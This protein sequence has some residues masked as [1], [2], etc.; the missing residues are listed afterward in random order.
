M[1]FAMVDHSLY[2]V[3]AHYGLTNKIHCNRASEQYREQDEDP[4]EVGGLE[5]KEAEKVVDNKGVSPAA[6]VDYHGGEGLPEKYHA[7]KV[8]R[9]H[10]L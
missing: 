3:C 10:Y 1:H 4:R 7:D 6:D 9:S 8:G 5:A 2:N